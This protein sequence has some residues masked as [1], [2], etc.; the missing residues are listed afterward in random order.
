MSTRI[1]AETTRARL[2]SAA[3]QDIRQIGAA[4]MTMTG[5]ATRLGMSH[6]NI[7]RFFPHKA[8]LV[9]AVLNQWLKGLET[10]LTDIADGPDPADDKLERYLTTLARAYADQLAQEAALFSLL[11]QPLPDAAEPERHAKRVL[12]LLTRII[13]EGMA[14]R[15]FGGADVKRGVQLAQ[16]LAYRFISPLALGS[17]QDRAS[18]TRRD[19]VI[20]SA[21]RALTSLRG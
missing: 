19:R 11:A 6:A 16:D 15:L 4:R 12:T 21:V 8:A 2:I 3:A 18:D 13:E 1:S 5:L 20:R 14:T 7:Y 10:R 9:D 17:A